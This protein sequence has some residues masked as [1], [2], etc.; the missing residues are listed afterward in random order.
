[1]SG[2]DWIKG[3]IRAGVTLIEYGDFQC[4]ACASYAGV[5]KEL[6]STFPNELRIVYRHFPLTQIHRNAL[7]AARAAEAAGKQGKFWEMH[8]LLFEKQGLWSN[9]G[10]AVALFLEYAKSLGLDEEKFKRDYDSSEVRARIEAQLASANALGLNSTPSFLLNG[11]K[12]LNPKTLADFQALVEAAIKDTPPPALN[13][14]DLAAAPDVHEHAGFALFINGQK[15]DFSPTKYQSDKN[16][17]D[18]E[19]ADHDHASHQHDPYTH[20]HDKKGQIIHKHKAG[21]TL[22]YF[23]KTLGMELTDKCLTTDDGTRYCSEE[24][25]SLK[26]FVNGKRSTEYDQYEITDLDRLLISYGPPTDSDL[27]EQ[28]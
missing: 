27:Q 15:F 25:N 5:V 21:V 8:D 17:K 7:P 10:N 23:L 19:E 11:K 26:F 16:D 28:L 18:E 13:S 22:G 1:M 4:P 6:A 12:L 14:D 20:L 2:D 9:E 3:G 24:K